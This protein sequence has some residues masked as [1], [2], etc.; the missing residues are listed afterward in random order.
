[1]DV[2]KIQIIQEEIQAS[3]KSSQKHFIQPL[4][5]CTLKNFGCGLDIPLSYAVKLN[6][7]H[8]SVSLIPLNFKTGLIFYGVPWIEVLKLSDAVTQYIAETGVFVWRD[9][10]CLFCPN[11]PI[12][13]ITIEFTI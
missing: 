5:E 2:N 4:V 7:N 10:R 3:Y 1:M 8:K 11:I 9:K 6:S 13:T 12:Q